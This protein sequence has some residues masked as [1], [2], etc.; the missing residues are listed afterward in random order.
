MTK[1]IEKDS[2]HGRVVRDRA[3]HH[4]RGPVLLRHVIARRGNKGLELFR[5]SLGFDEEAL[6][7]FSSRRAAQNFA[8]SSA[9]EREWYARECSAGELTSL[10][11]G[12]YAGIEWVLLDPLPGRLAAGDTPT[13]LM[14]WESFI[15]YL[16]G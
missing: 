10:L 11:L 4:A 15:D 6:L 1:A 12:P 7:V 13:N 3:G 9:L 2:G 8:F 14:R 16:L 5:L